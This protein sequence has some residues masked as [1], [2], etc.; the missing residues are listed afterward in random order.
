MQELILLEDFKTGMPESVVVHLNEQ[1]ATK[2]S[3]AAVLADEF[4]LTHRTF[5]LSGC[6]MKT[7]LSAEPVAQVT[8]R[9]NGRKF[10]S[11]AKIVFKKM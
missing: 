9:D 4:A 2:L 7:S 6:Q 1:K 3:E 11:R 10:A 8:M 5:F